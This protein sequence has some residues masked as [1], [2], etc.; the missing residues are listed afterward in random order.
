MKRQ[1]PRAFK[2]VGYS[3]P[4]LFI[5]LMFLLRE[6]GSEYATSLKDNPGPFF[7][8]ITFGL[9]IV[10]LSRDKI[11]DERTNAIRLKCFQ[12]AV[13][14]GVVYVILN[15][16]GLF[17]DPGL[18]SSSRVMATVALVYI[19]SFESHKRFFA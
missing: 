1:L 15:S 3:I 5:G 19:I 16:F 4:I 13:V 7:A 11:E 14:F 2:F 9:L 12:F 17:E 6:V 10:I 18:Y 8:S